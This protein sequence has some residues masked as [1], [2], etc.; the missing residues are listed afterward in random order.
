MASYLLTVEEAAKLLRVDTTTIRRYIKLKLLEDVF[1]LPNLD[2][3]RHTW[4]IPIAS[5]AAML[6]TSEERLWP[7]LPESVLNPKQF[8]EEEI[9]HAES[10]SVL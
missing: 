8:D 3:R 6:K 5:L 4:R 9:D 10:L 1:G 2:T 7:F